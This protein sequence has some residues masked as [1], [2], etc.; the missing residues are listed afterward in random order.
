MAVIQFNSLCDLLR[1]CLPP[2][3]AVLHVSPGCPLTLTLQRSCHSHLRSLHSPHLPFLH[4]PTCPS[5]PVSPHIGYH[6][7]VNFICSLV[8]CTFFILGFLLL[9]L[10]VPVHGPVVHIVFI[11]SITFLELQNGYINVIVPNVNT[12]LHLGDYF[13]APPDDGRRVVVLVYCKIMIINMTRGLPYHAVVL[14][15]TCV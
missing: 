8:T 12:T 10:S 1:K 3:V 2:L 4:L 6:I 7:Y 14:R 9:N 5:I 11:K 15:S 13:W